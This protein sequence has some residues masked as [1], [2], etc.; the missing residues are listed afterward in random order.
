MIQRIQ[1]IFLLLVSASLVMSFFL[2]FGTVVSLNETGQ[3]T[4][5]PFTAWGVSAF[6]PIAFTLATLLAALIPFITIFLYKNRKLQIR[7]CLLEDVLLLPVAASLIIYKEMNFEGVVFSNFVWL[8]VVS[9]L[10]P[11]LFNLFALL[12]IKKDEKLIRSL[13]RIR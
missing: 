11:Y 3:S 9:F 5:Q 13:D 4:I 2:P 7:F 1:T 8:L 10:L 6:R 12:A